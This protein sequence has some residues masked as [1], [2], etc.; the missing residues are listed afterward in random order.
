MNIFCGTD[1]IEISRI[2]DAIENNKSFLENVF[3]ENEIKYCESHKAQKYQH[4]AARFAAK[5]AIYKSISSKINS[6]IKWKD[7]EIINTSKG[8]PTVNFLNKIEGLETI[9][10]SLSH[11]KEY[12]V[13]TAISVFKN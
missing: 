8:R 10:I 6:E 3:T 11:C 2:K 1:I 9:D 12:A 13:A 5:E 7:Y 4:F